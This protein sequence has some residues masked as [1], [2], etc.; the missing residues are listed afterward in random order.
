MSV[1]GGGDVWTLARGGCR[2]G[3]VGGGEVRPGTFTRITTGGRPIGGGEALACGAARGLRRERTR[4]GLLGAWLRSRAETPH[5]A[6]P[7][8]G[9]SL[10]L[11]GIS[12]GWTA[13]E[14]PS[15]PRLG[16]GAVLSQ[17]FDHWRVTGNRSGRQTSSTSRQYQVAPILWVMRPPAPKSHDYPE[18]ADLYG[19]EAQTYQEIMSR[20]MVSRI[21]HLMY[22]LN[23][24]LPRPFL[25]LMD[26][27]GGG[28]GVSLRRPRRLAWIF[29]SGSSAPATRRPGMIAHYEAPLVV[30]AFA[31]MTRL[32]LP[33]VADETGR[34]GASW[35]LFGADL[36]AAA[37]REHRA[38]RPDPSDTAVFGGHISA[39]PRRRFFL[40]FFFFFFFVVRYLAH[41]PAHR[42]WVFNAADICTH[43][44][45]RAR[46]RGR[47]RSLPPASTSTDA[48][49]GL[50]QPDASG[51]A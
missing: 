21:H 13:R 38:R 27:A 34:S 32:G 36:H 2:V 15:R 5:P 17:A 29:R 47:R 1:D 8:V 24:D 26:G 7:K 40:F 49:S 18:L 22:R 45:S 19:W 28:D 9:A 11:V 20:G 12:C 51:T 3:T 33:P 46:D 42:E 31:L 43:L 25:R 14:S 39:G 6:R 37:H 16:L 50:P 10:L 41:H 30:V 4:L 35:I 44:R 48:A 23:S